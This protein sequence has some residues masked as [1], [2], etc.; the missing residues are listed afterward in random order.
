VSSLERD[1]QD[2]IWSLGAPGELSANGRCVCRS[3]IF[4]HAP[5]RFGW[6]GEPDPVV[7]TVHGSTKGAD[8]TLGHVAPGGRDS[9]VAGLRMGDMWNAREYAVMTGRVCSARLVRRLTFLFLPPPSFSVFSLLP[10][11]RLSQTVYRPAEIGVRPLRRPDSQRQALCAGRARQPAAPPLCTYVGPAVRP[12]RD[13]SRSTR[14]LL[15]IWISERW[16]SNCVRPRIGRHLR[17]RLDTGSACSAIA[18]VR[19]PP[20]L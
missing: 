20:V 8:P 11:G 5:V 10:T 17:R 2:S 1:G 14:P 7:S 9:E 16:T 3:Q 13:S 6:R 12:R 15:C 4:G 19:R 18:A